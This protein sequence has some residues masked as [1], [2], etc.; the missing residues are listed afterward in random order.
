MEPS[1]T[2]CS[3]F[4]D[5]ESNESQ[6][7]KIPDYQRAYAWEEKQIAAF[8]GDI[9]KYAANP[10][11]YYFGHFIIEENNGTFEIVDGQQ[12]ITTIV[13]FLLVCRHLASNEAQH[14]AYSLIEKFCPVNYD[15][16]TFKRISQNLKSLFDAHPSFDA[17]Q[18]SSLNEEAISEW[19]DPESRTRSQLRMI[20]ALLQFHQAFKSAKLKL[21]Q[22]HIDDYLKVIMQSQCSSH[23]PAGKSSV[24]IFE[25]H[26][27]RGVGLTTMEI[28]K[29]KLMKFVYDHGGDSKN[30]KVEEIQ[31]EFGEIYAME[32]KLSNADFRGRL[33]LEQLFR[34]H[35]RVIDDGNKVDP[36]DFK[37]PPEDASADET[38][39][40]LDGKL[41]DFLNH[42]T[43]A[44][45]EY[46]VT[47][48]REFKNSVWIVCV[49]LP[50]WDRDDHLVGDVLVLERN[51]SC[52]FYL[53]VCRRLESKKGANDGV[54]N[55]D[56]LR[57]WERLLFIRNFHPKYHGLRHRDN[58]PLIFQ[59][60]RRGE[61]SLVISLTHYLKAGFRKGITDDLPS[62]V[63]SYW[64]DL[65]KEFLENAYLC[66]PEK[67][68]YL[69]YK[70]EVRADSGLNKNRIRA[71]VKN[72][73]S[74]EHILP[75][76]WDSAWL[77]EKGLEG[78]STSSDEEKKFVE[79]FGRRING[80]GNLLLLTSSEN[81]SATNKH[82]SEKEYSRYKS[83]GSYKWHEENKGKWNKAENWSSIIEKRG[84]ELLIFMHEHFNIPGTAELRTQLELTA[85]LPG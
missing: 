34:L 70:Y 52:Q 17:T 50:A 26:N 24:N 78:S 16:D 32:E 45:V 79:K 49:H 66:W 73:I 63:G 83:A 81:S 74:V 25:M 62:I 33:S 2:F 31:K 6:S 61:E 60:I 23:H 77:P 46:A 44:G 7:I 71:L 65:R 27:T 40:Y 20:R 18:K 21:N 85:A 30:T 59:E 8:I 36:G 69:L 29:A 22:D 35:C 4:F 1:S 68:K 15:E 58:F 9:V 11:D 84:V 64:K 5:S 12:R 39:S 43:S 72:G 41:A 67:M 76:G 10:S 54:L 53:L 51:I 55:N 13:L 48:A 47:L 14:D 28:I 37:S 57:A 19:I 56:A 42:K 75:Q 80:L 38:V 82:P 3:I